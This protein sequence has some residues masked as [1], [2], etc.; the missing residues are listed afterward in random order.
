MRHLREPLL[1]SELASL[2]KEQNSELIELYGTGCRLDI[3][4]FRRVCVFA[5]QQVVSHMAYNVT[6]ECAW[7]TNHTK[8]SRVMMKLASMVGVLYTL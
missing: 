8:F 2:V 6:H 7:L 4:T 3:D 5:F 1:L